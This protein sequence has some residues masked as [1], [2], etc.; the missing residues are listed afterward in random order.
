M[1]RRPLRA[2][3]LG[4]AAAIG[5]GGTGAAEAPATAFGSA[6]L[7][8]TAQLAGLDGGDLAEAPVGVPFRI[9]LDFRDPG[10]P[11]RAVT[12]PVAWL[13]PLGPTAS[14]CQDSAR[15]AR[16]TGRL[17]G[18]DVPLAGLSLVTLDAQNR[19]AIV[20]PHRPA[21]A[22][23]VAG[24]VPM[25]GRPGGFAVHP[26]RGELVYG[27]PDRG[28]VVTVPLPFGRPAILA[29]GLAGPRAL[30]PAPA[31]RLW[32]A[33]DDHVR[34][35]DRGGATLLALPLAGPDLH[36]AG[37]GRLLA[38]GRDG[39]GLM[40]DRG[41]G[42]VV[43][44]FAP[45]SLAGIAAATPDSVLTIRDGGLV[46]L[47][48]DSPGRP[49][50]LD[51]PGMP[52]AIRA[53]EAGRWAVVLSRRE[54]EAR[55][56]DGE[57]GA[58]ELSVLDLGLGRRIHGFA[59]PEPFDEAVILGNTV[60]LTWPTR[61]VVTVIDLAALRSGDA[62]SRDVRLG[63][64]EGPGLPRR[65]PM[66]AP[67]A[68]LPA[69]AVMRPGGRLLHVVLAGG[70]LSSAPAQVIALKG[71]PPVA[72]AA[73]PRSLV[74]RGEGAF[75]ATAQLPRGGAWEL[76]TTTGTGGTTACL[77]IPVE[78][79]PPPPPVPR[80]EAEVGA[81]EAG[82]VILAIRLKD[83]PAARP[84]GALPLRLTALDGSDVRDVAA[85]PVGE[86]FVTAAL[87][88]SPGLYA[89]SL[90]DGSPLRPDPAIVALR[91]GRSR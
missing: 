16:V 52:L 56:R 44:R 27:R 74:P 26:E 24:I 3:P 69:V 32:L 59:A 45:G 70:G 91:P 62:A 23:I 66:M 47:Y 6:G 75:E 15:A 76:V 8:V 13:R 36:G 11:A 87:R 7:A 53:D 83:W 46:R 22:R 67:L 84:P 55:A 81:G 28:D 58:F 2:V 65:G 51:V 82:T 90:A 78:A 68:P 49:D 72:L 31:G 43:A 14:T 1:S 54:V 77:P 39:A 18:D 9:R 48:A 29:A 5:W 12:G 40:L 10:G 60:F 33:E 80:L 25:E 30:L 57:A 37:P 89:V 86:A 71:D 42:A 73:F 4:L 63:G 21:S 64:P 85:D 35:L 50:A 88:A 79:T 17:S 34:L 61:P 20:D 19:V 41:T 38:A